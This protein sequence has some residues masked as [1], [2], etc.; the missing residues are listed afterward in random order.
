MSKIPLDPVPLLD[1]PATIVDSNVGDE[2]QVIR[3]PAL[4]LDSPHPPQQGMLNKVIKCVRFFSR[5]LA[6]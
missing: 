2:T 1:P 3:H 6:F 5:K 4:A